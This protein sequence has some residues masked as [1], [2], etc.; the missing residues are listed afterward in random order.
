MFIFKV[1]LI[2]CLISLDNNLSQVLELNKPTLVSVKGDDLL[3]KKLSADKRKHQIQQAAKEIFLKKG[4]DRTVMKDIMEATGLSRGGL[5]H[6]YSST[7]EI[8]CDILKTGNQQRIDTME[9]TFDQS[10]ERSSTVLAQLTVDKMLAYNDY[11]RIYVMFL[12]ELKNDQS[13]I[14][15]HDQLKAMSIANIQELLKQ[16]NYPPLPDNQYEFLTN[17]I[18]TFLVGCDVLGVRENFNKQ[19]SALVCMLKTYFDT[20]NESEEKQ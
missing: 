9:K 6:H 17:L 10:T 16:F 14:E 19:R 2:F 11:L 13:L 20:I 1:N 3:S 18:N 15:L 4:F 8:L 7:T 12:S 5:Y